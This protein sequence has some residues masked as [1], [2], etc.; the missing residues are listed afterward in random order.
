MKKIIYPAYVVTVLTIIFFLLIEKNAYA[1][2]KYFLS[3]GTLYDVSGGIVLSESDGGDDN[4][5]SD[6]SVDERA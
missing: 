2:S 4:K 3:K 5:D 1:Y 6:K